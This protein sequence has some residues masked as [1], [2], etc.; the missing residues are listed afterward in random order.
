MACCLLISGA[1]G[2]ILAVK[3]R[4]LGRSSGGKIEALTWR[5]PTEDDDDCK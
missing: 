4:L 3:A 2:L 5:R 1:I